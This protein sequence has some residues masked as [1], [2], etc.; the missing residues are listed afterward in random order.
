MV[1]AVLSGVGFGAVV[2]FTQTSTFVNV[3][4]PASVVANVDTSTLPGRRAEDAGDFV[5]S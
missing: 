2:P 3:S 5:G 4:G 1:P